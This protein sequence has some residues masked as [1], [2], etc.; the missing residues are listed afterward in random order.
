MLPCAGHVH[1][2]ACAHLRMHVHACVCMCMQ[3]FPPLVSTPR[4]LKSPT[5]L[6]MA[7][8]SMARAYSAVY[9]YTYSAVY[10]YTYSAI[11][12]ARAYSAAVL[13]NSART[14]EHMH[15]CYICSG[16]EQRKGGRSRDPMARGSKAG[17]GIKSRRRTLLSAS[18]CADSLPSPPSPPSLPSRRGLL[19]LPYSGEKLRAV[20][21]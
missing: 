1:A 4:P 11:C 20:T 9:I 17:Q 3:C 6:W 14:G 7:V 18:F 2:Y 19:R 21:R 10:V 13:V 16:G 15:V 12:M 5:H 8:H